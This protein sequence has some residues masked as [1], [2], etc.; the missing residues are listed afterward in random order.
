M[1]PYTINKGINVPLV[2]KGLKAQYIAYLAVGLVVL[3]VLFAVAYMLG[4]SKYLCLG[5]ALVLG[6]A[7][8]Y[9]VFHYSGK[10]GQHG[11]MKATAYRQVPQSI[12]CRSR[13]PFLTLK[14]HT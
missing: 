1:N 5:G 13:K 9:G 12:R 3:L 2:F 7:L 10:Y 4:L 6:G 8:F 11:L 14:D